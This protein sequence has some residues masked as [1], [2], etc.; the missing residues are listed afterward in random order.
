MSAARLDDVVDRFGFAI[1]RIPQVFE[2]RDKRFG[3]LKIR[4][5]VDGRRDHV[6]AALPHVDVIVGV[7]LPPELPG[8]QRGDHL[9]GVHVGAGPRSGLENVERKVSVVVTTLDFLG[10]FLDGRCHAG[11]HQ[12]Q[13]LVDGG[14]SSFD[15]AKGFPRTSVGNAGR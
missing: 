6:V 5:D 10:R 14:S 4:A 15:Q 9:V 11:F 2:A 1:D 3:D 12:T 13:I 8:R 7:H